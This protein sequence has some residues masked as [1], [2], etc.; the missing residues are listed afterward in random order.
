MNDQHW[1]IESPQTLEID[2]VTELK[3]NA[4]GG[5]FDVVVH[6]E[7][8][9]R[10][11]IAEISGDSLEIHFSNGALQIKH[12]HHDASRWLAKN[13]PVE[14]PNRLVITISVP[15]TTA[16]DAGTVSGDGLVQGINGRVK[17][18]LVSGSVISDSTQGSVAANTVSG[19]VI[20]RDHQGDLSLNS[21][22]GEMTASG[23]LSSVKTNTGT[24]DVTLDCLGP[25]QKISSN[26]VSGDLLIRLPQQL[27]VD[28]SATS[29]AS[30][31]TINDESIRV[32]GNTKRSF[33]E[34]SN[35][36]VQIN[37]VSVTGAISVVNQLS[38]VQN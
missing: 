13:N 35:G 26:S 12:G 21:V 2:D 36:A 11:A 7:P 1:S 6:D 17:V 8:V 31:I 23:A 33:G 37:C 32:L 18:S 5:R 24:G 9:T 22:S 38:G 29:V 34:R 19:E 30:N 15:A 10:L 27:A 28:L 16:I 25:I 20:V 14:S 4:V 3:L